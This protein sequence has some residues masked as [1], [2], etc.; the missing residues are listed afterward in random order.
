MAAGQVVATLP[1]VAVGFVSGV[2]SGMFGIG[3]GVVT[4][5]AIR[6]ALGYPA[7]VAVG[8]P[9]LVIIPTTV[10]GAWSYRRSGL[11]D[12]RAGLVI[13]AFGIPTAVLGALAT[14]YVGGTTVLVL[15]AGLM[16][17]MG[18]DVVW[19]LWRSR[20]GEQSLA[21]VEDEGPV[22]VVEG[23][24]MGDTSAHS[25]VAVASA[26]PARG[27]LTTWVLLG[28]TTGA[29]SGFLGL[30]GG[31]VLVPLL[32]RV[33]KMPIKQAIGTSLVAISVL[34]IP[35]VATHWALGHIDV[36]LAV[37]LIVGSI[38]GALVGARITRA[39]RERT[40]RLGFAA[41]LIVVGVWLAVAELTGA[42]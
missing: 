30:G 17:Y 13:G 29:Y 27:R 12:M 41:L 18:G 39:S 2:L 28:L 4:T 31:F 37:A 14:K 40:V 23:R 16:L 11:A 6:I 26:A 19:N 38:P 15:T 3:G 21:P 22:V 5:P 34:A 8:T 10:T 20:H 7:L 36:R 32:Q 25:D 35:G 24:A 9:L 42:G 1:A 33:A